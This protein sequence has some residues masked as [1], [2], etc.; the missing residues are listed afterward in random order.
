MKLKYIE[1]RRARMN[2]DKASIIDRNSHVRGHSARIDNSSET[3]IA[4]HMGHGSAW[5][6]ESATS[7]L[8]GDKKTSP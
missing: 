2:N 5:P 8:A 6:L 3:L 1:S 4:A 7:Y